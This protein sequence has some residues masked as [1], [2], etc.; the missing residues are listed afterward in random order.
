MAPD[1]IEI[2]SSDTLVYLG[3]TLDKNAQINKELTK[4][5]GQAWVFFCEAAT[6]SESFLIVS[7]DDVRDIPKCYHH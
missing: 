7:V 4:K 3:A 2:P 1:G 6:P 5:I